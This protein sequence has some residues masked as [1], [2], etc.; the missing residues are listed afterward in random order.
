[1][2]KTLTMLGIG[3]A[4]VASLIMV[5]GPAASAASWNYVGSSEF[6]VWVSKPKKSAGGNFLTCITTSST[7]KEFYTLKEA[8]ADHDNDL[9]GEFEGGGCIKWKDIGGAVDGS[10]HRAEF[11]IETTDAE[12]LRVKSYD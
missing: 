8:D 4:A 2:R 10:N 1:M 6:K 11:Y 5:S 7:T 12:A 3:S 9:V